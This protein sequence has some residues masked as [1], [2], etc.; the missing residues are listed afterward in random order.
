MARYGVK[1]KM[2]PQGVIQRAVD[3]F[4][5]GGAGLDLLERS[6]CCARFEGGGG[7]VSVTVSEQDPTEVEVVTR[8]FDYE[9][10]QFVRQV[11]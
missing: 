5:E 2:D 11:G 3:F 6:P 4:G 1:T 9:V 10:K 8:E 7:H